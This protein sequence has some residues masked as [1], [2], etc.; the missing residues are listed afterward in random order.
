VVR[1]AGAL[2]AALESRAGDLTEG[3]ALPLFA[4][5]RPAARALH[6]PGPEPAPTAPSAAD[7]LPAAVAALD[8]DRLTPREALEALYRLKAMLA[9]EA[10]PIAPDAEPIT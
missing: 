10:R 1:R 2:L 4:A 5:A 6:G 9:P 7:P 3:G 8:P